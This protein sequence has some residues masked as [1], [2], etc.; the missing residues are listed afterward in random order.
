M[1]RR[2]GI[3]N[4][5]HSPSIISALRKCGNEQTKY[6]YIFFSSSRATC[7]KRFPVVSLILHLYCETINAPTPVRDKA[8]VAVTSKAMRERFHLRAVFLSGCYVFLAYAAAL[9]AGNKKLRASMLVFRYTAFPLRVVRFVL[10]PPAETIVIGWTGWFTFVEHYTACKTSLIFR[11]VLP[12][13]YTSLS[14]SIDT[15]IDTTRR[16]EN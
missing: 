7:V 2:F 16:K 4:L 13:A 12:L 9:R 11:R 14:S 5:R 10:R 6:I 15:E 1:E 3:R 8:E